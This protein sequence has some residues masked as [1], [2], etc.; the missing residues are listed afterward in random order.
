[1]FEKLVF[2]TLNVH[3][4]G[5]V[6][7]VEIAVPPMNLLGQNWFAIWSP[8]FRKPRPTSRA[9]S[10]SRAPTPTISSPTSM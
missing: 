10:F 9:C 6:L 8:S 3:Q 7:F 4:E 1:M 2:E 5:V